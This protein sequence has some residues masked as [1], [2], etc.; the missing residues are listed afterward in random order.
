MQTSDS[1]STVHIL[2]SLAQIKL[3]LPIHYTSYTTLFLKST[4]LSMF[5]KIISPSNCCLL[6]D[7][8]MSLPLVQHF[9]SSSS[10]MA[11]SFMFR[12]ISGPLRTYIKN[13]VTFRRKK[14]HARLLCRISE[15][16]LSPHLLQP[17][18]AFKHASSSTHYITKLQI[19]PTNMAE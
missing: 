14:I 3:Q 15:C 10:S 16:N 17:F 19:S 8:S 18:C 11:S 7:F 4:S 1:A 13:L 9:F 5:L 6:L 12:L 2:W